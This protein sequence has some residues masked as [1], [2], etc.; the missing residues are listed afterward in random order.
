MEIKPS[1][2]HRPFKLGNSSK[3]EQK[4]AFAL[5]LVG[6]SQPGYQCLA[7]AY[8]RESLRAD[9]RLAGLAVG[10]LEFD[11]SVSAW[12][13]VYHLLS[14]EYEPSLVGFSVYCWNA[15]T[16]YEALRILSTVRPDLPVVLGGPEV[17]PL[18]EEV[19]ERF[20]PQV[21]YVAPGEGER[22]ICDLVDLLMSGKSR[23][24]IKHLPE[25]DATLDLDTIPSPYNEVQ[26]PPIDGSAYIESYRGCPHRCSYCYESKGIA[27]I[28][29]FSW[30]RIAADIEL[31][32]TTPGVKSFTFVDSAFNL[33][34]ARLQK[35][36]DILAPYAQRGIR[37]HT[38]EV[39]V[40]SI[41]DEQASLLRRAGVVS[42]ETGPQTTGAK[43]LELS[44]RSLDKEAY[45]KGVEACRRA[46]ITV[47]AD[48]ILGLPGDS[49]E[50]CLESMRFVIQDSDPG[51][52]QAS[53]LHVLPGTLLWDR[54]DELGLAY[55]EQAP[56]AVIQTAD[57]SFKE[58]RELEVFSAALSALYRTG[59]S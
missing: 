1:Q 8:L 11:T 50:T 46:G 23:D 33:T 22:I 45:L 20:A 59:I 27:Q 26:R 34:K 53:S 5:A 44:Q 15:N 7:N 17:G 28:R 6:I 4:E 25:R 29:S 18:A 57:I 55:D 43:A 12:W 9:E 16:V 30:P 13:I 58:L 51:V 24:K 52:L 47:I 21:I 40:E 49:V 54:A 14:Q 35:L 56:H 41:D 48:L 32:A 19:H 39:D 37:L 3:E 31:L 42:V 2:E 36:S 38:I 10:N